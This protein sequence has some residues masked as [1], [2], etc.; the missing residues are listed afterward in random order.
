MKYRP[1]EIKALKKDIITQ[2]GALLG[3]IRGDINQ[4]LT[5]ISFQ[6]NIYNTENIE[7]HKELVNKYINDFYIA[8][9]ESL[10]NSNWSFVKLPKSYDDKPTILPYEK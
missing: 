3:E 5:S 7:Q 8:F 9:V 4:S 6:V 1:E 10:N 2:T